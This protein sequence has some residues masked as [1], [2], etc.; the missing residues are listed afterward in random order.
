MGEHQ[1]ALPVEDEITAELQQVFL[2]VCAVR[3]PA[4]QHHREEAAQDA[5]PKERSP[6]RPPQS[7]ASIRCHQWV[8]DHGERPAPLLLINRQRLGP[9]GTDDHHLAAQVADVIVAFL[10]LAEVRL[11]GDSGK[12][13]QEDQDQRPSAEIRQPDRRPVGPRPKEIVNGIADAQ[14]D[15]VSSAA[16]CDDNERWPLAQSCGEQ[17]M[18]DSLRAQLAAFDPDL[19]LERAHTIPSSW[20]FDPEIYAAECRHVFG[21]TWQVVGRLD[22]VAE[23]GSYLTADIAGEPVLVVRDQEGT[24]RAFA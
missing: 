18:S 21:N 4:A 13:A 2:V 9:A 24:L 3:Q 11:T 8:S 20:Y 22:Q 6:R 17:P 12:V 16:C 7:K 19:P 14:H 15:G 1:P 5:R 23:P 10:H